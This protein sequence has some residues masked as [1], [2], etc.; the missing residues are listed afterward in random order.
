MGGTADPPSLCLF[1]PTDICACSDPVG[2][3]VVFGT[4]LAAN[5]PV[6]AATVGVEP[7]FLSDSIPLSIPI[8]QPMTTG[9]DGSYAIRVGD[10][11]VGPDRELLLK[12][13]PD[14]T[15]TV[16]SAII[17]FTPTWL[18]DSMRIDVTLEPK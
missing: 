18:V 6:S 5:A 7:R 4:I 17:G 14:S 8:F 2:E 10:I 11:V 1:C 9:A 16:G 15:S 3:V 13:I 12:V